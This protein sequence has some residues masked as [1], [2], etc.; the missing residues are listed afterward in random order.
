MLD[1]DVL[2]DLIE[3][4]MDDDTE[5]VDVRAG[6]KLSKEEIKEFLEELCADDPDEEVE[7]EEAAPEEILGELTESAKNAVKNERLEYGEQYVTDKIDLADCM[8]RIAF[9]MDKYIPI[10]HGD[11]TKY[12]ELVRKMFSKNAYPEYV[13]KLYGAVDAMIQS[14]KKDIGV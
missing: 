14:A 11:V 8:T 9:A 13:S 1:F 10:L 6:R 3:M 12:N 2:K 7:E 4:V 5:V